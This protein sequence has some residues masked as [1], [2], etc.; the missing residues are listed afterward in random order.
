MSAEITRYG[1]IE[2]EAEFVGPDGRS[3]RVALEQDFDASHHEAASSRLIIVTAGP[4]GE[5]KQVFDGS[6]LE[7]I[8][9]ALLDLRNR[10][11]CARR[12]T[13]GM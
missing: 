6:Q 13:V 10:R 12:A 9:Q 4:D 5:A 7:H 1:S 11:D 3:A 8:L 2:M